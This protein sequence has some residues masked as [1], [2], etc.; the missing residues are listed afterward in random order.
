MQYNENY[1]ET[2]F[3]II[4]TIFSRYNRAILTRMLDV[5][6]EKCVVNYLWLN[7]MF[8]FYNMEPDLMDLWFRAALPASERSCGGTKEA[9]KG[10]SSVN[11]SKYSE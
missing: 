10:V 8:N 3:V 2:Y 11:N 4:K 9:N 7:W 6:T 5:G 1:C